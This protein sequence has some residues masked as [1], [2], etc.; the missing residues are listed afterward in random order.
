MKNRTDPNKAEKS[1][2]FG[3]LL[4]RML[5]DQ[6]EQKLKSKIYDLTWPEIQRKGQL[7]Q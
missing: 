5:K 2:W 7:L 1:R 4:I 3:C 6:K